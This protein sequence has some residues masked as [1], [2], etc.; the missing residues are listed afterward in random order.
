M[1]GY[2]MVPLKSWMMEEWSFGCAYSNFSMN[3]VAKFP[4]HYRGCNRRTSGGFLAGIIRH[5]DVAQVWVGSRCT[6]PFELDRAYM[7]WQLYRSPEKAEIYPP[8]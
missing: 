1:H 4:I 6:Y 2:G 7:A 5:F 8:F 3:N